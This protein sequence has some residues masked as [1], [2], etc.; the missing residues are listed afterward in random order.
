MKWSSP[1]PLPVGEIR[2]GGGTHEWSESRH[3]RQKPR[4][5][6]PWGVSEMKRL[7]RV[8][9]TAAFPNASETLAGQRHRRDA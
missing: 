2:K 7:E 6:T 9:L 3:L 1:M 5:M 8:P 4:P